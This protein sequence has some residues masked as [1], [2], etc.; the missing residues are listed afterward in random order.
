MFFLNKRITAVSARM[1]TWEVLTA[2]DGTLTETELRKRFDDDFSEAFED[3]VNALGDS[4]ANRVGCCDVFEKELRADRVFFWPLIS[5]NATDGRK[6]RFLVSVAN[7]PLACYRKKFDRCLPNQ[8]ALYAIADKILRGEWNYRCATAEGFFGE[9]ACDESGFKNQSAISS[10]AEDGNLLLVALWNNVLYVLVFVKGRLCHWSE[11]CGYGDSIDERCRNRV[12]RF[13]SFLK[14]DD[15]FA[16]AGEASAKSSFGEV[17][18]CCNHLTDM[19]ELFWA[20]ARDPFWRLLDLDKCCTMKAC[21]KRRW[22]MRLTMLLTL[23]MAL[24]LTCGNSGLWNCPWEWLR[25]WNGEAIADG[26]SKVAP[27]ELSLPAAHDLEKLAWAEGHR[28]MLPAK[29]GRLRGDAAVDEPRGRLQNSRSGC[30]SSAITLLGIVGGRA[31]L[32]VTAAGEMKTL[33]QGD[34]LFSYRVKAIGMGDVVLRCGG[35]EV[36]YAIRAR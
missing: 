29:W 30:D 20:G 27:V 31:A 9:S 12:E 16:N 2:F 6:H 19:D 18:V 15:L 4:N 35:K 14:M 11:D 21:E 3:D 36:R 32:V 34:S 10:A 26:V 22:A 5:F 1:M 28:D 13:K 24:A 7:E 17:Y 25:S 8:V 33:S 23:C